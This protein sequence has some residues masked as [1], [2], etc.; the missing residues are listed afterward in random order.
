MTASGGFSQLRPARGKLREYTSAERPLELEFDFNPST[1]TRTR[2]VTLRPPGAPGTRGGF[3]FQ[4]EAEAIRAAQGVTVNAESFTIKILLD[5]TDLMDSGDA[6]AHENGVQP[7]LDI[8]RSMLE[9]KIQTPEGAR[10]LS[11]IGQGNQ[12]AFS[13]Q[14]Y[15]SVLL[16]TWGAYTV[17]VFM[18]QAQIDLKEFLP[19]LTPYR[20]E[21]TLTLQIIESDNPIYKDELRRQFNSAQQ[22]TRASPSPSTGGAR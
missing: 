20:A 13:R 18:T 11:A 1:I 17:P 9:P 12:R 21:A 15:A 14:V 5:A 6:D 19:N 3:D 2:S 7:Q 8:I 10:T 4:N 22:S 16:F